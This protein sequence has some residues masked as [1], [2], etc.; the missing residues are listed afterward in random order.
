[1]NRFFT[2][3]EGNS[4]DISLDIDNPLERRLLTEYGAVLVAGDG[5]TPPDR[6]IFRN[7]DE[8][9][10][11][12]NKLSAQTATLGGYEVELQAAALAGLLRAVSDA[13]AAGLDITPRGSGSARRRYDETESLWLSRVHP[14]LDHWLA[15]GRLS[16]EQAEHIR[17]LSAFEQVSEVLELEEQNIFFSKDL[18][19]SIIYS[20]APPGTSQHLSMLAIDRAEFN[21]PPIREIMYSHGWFQTV[22]SDLPHF[23]YLGLH[24]SELPGMG[25]KQIINGD[26]GFWVPDLD[27]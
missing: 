8:V 20:V 25:L 1:M 24:T 27:P 12:Q 4:R 15:V 6:L 16:P 14:A 9:D 2:T 11:F 5:V 21:D 13:R 22:I 10:T 19:K 23:T 3:L 26:R 17:S 7:S 18:S